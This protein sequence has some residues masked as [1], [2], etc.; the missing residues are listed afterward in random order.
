[1]AISTIDTLKGHLQSVTADELNAALQDLTSAKAENPQKK[2]EEVSALATEY[3]VLQK[4]LDRLAESMTKEGYGSQ[5]SQRL[6]AMVLIIHALVLIGET[7][8]PG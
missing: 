1:M 6:D 5:T 7:R 2:W 4:V 3:P 8:D